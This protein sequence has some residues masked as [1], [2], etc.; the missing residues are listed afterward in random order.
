MESHS[1]YKMWGIIYLCKYQTQI[2]MHDLKMGKMHLQSKFWGR[3]CTPESH[4]SRGSLV[5]CFA[6]S[7]GLGHTL[8]GLVFWGFGHYCSV[9]VV[10]AFTLVV[11]ISGTLVISLNMHL[12]KLCEENL[13]IYW[14]RVGNFCFV[15]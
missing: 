6:Y 7:T 8:A 13:K 2:Y 5:W 15:L 1:L 3:T 14:I 11:D 10:A 4:R 9:Q 12:S